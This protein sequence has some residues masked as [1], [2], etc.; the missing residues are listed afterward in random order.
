[1][2]Q[3]KS[4]KVRIIRKNDKVQELENTWLLLALKLQNLLS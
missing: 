3:T 4:K 2:K 1:M